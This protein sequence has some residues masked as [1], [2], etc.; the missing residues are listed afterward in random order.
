[1]LAGFQ[2]ASSEAHP[3]I[4]DLVDAQAERISALESAVQDLTAHSAEQAATVER[5]QDQ[6]KSLQSK[7]S[8]QSLYKVNPESA[9]HNIVD[10]RYM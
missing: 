7:V 4:A 3:S 6:L 8:S 10:C 9:F 1:M 2:A 5:L